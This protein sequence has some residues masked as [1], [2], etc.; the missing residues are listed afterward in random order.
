ML[1]QR[2]CT[3]K[4]HCLLPWRL[5]NN[6]GLPWVKFESNHFAQIIP[7]VRFSLV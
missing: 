7:N 6:F 3:E 4:K 2:V 1:E 5:E